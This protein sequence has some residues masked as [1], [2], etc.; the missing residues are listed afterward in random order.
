MLLTD[1][2]YGFCCLVDENKQP[3]VSHIIPNTTVTHMEGDFRNLRYSTHVRDDTIAVS[4][5]KLKKICFMTINGQFTKKVE[6]F[7]VHTPKAIY[8]LHNGNIAVSWDDPV[9]FGII[10]FRVLP[11]NEEVYFTHD[12]SGRQLKSFDYI[13]V[14]KE[15]RHVIQPC[16]V[17]KAVYCFKFDGQ[18][19][20]KYTSSELKDPRGV[21]VD[22]SGYI[23]ICD[24]GGGCIHIVCPDGQVARIVKEGCP[25][26]PLVI[27]FNKGK[28][29]F[30]VTESENNWE[31][32][33]FFSLVAN[34]VQS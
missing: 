7:C 24:M 17:D 16:K 21:D 12:K 14:D 15:R 6:I 10:S 26:K 22:G 13:T 29:N 27:G 9:A 23:Y 3:V 19:V 5:P 32:V 8:G 34:N 25:K 11:Y 33:H 4:L 28:H 30:A 31:S 2:F 20:F 18:P 1:S